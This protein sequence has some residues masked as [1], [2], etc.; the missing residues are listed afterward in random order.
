MWGD[1]FW[2]LEKDCEFDLSAFLLPDVN[3]PDSDVCT[4]TFDVDILKHLY[5][6]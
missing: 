6:K 2:L 1:S 4:D 5:T 3:D